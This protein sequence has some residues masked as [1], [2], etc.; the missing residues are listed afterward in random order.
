MRNMSKVLKVLEERRALCESC[1]DIRC[2][3]PIVQGRVAFAPPACL[4]DRFKD[5]SLPMPEENS[6][7]IPT[8]LCSGCGGGNAVRDVARA[9][10][11]AE[12]ERAIAEA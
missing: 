4:L 8:M 5:Y 10:T 12:M 6:A 2:A 9:R 11:P 1:R 3:I 7:S